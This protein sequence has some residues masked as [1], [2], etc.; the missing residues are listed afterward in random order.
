M[1]QPWGSSDHD[2]QDDPYF[3]QGHESL[4]MTSEVGEDANMPHK[5]KDE[6]PLVQQK[7]VH[8]R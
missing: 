4:K 8:A 6:L 5:G 1:T 3:S 2:M 7:Q